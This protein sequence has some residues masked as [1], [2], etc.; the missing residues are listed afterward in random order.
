MLSQS[1]CGRQRSFLSR[2]GPVKCEGPIPPPGGEARQELVIEQER[3]ELGR[4]VL[5]LQNTDF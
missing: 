3:T 5:S 2:A 1:R 4:H